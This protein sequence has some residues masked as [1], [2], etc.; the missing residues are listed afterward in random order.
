[1]WTWVVQ[2]ALQKDGH[3]TPL[4]HPL[5]HGCQLHGNKWN[6]HATSCYLVTL[7]TAWEKYSFMHIQSITSAAGTHAKI[8][9][10]QY[11]DLC[12]IT[13][14][15]S[16]VVPFVVWQSLLGAGWGSC[17]CYGLGMHVRRRLLFSLN[18]GHV[19]RNFLLIQGWGAVIGM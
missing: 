12:G 17:L 6:P 4:C 10:G 16:R 2:G 8:Q 7:I 3:M 1:M 9:E 13:W 18:P 14:D 15:N 11:C 5:V 19:F